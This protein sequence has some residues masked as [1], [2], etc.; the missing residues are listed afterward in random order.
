ME[1][2]R[3]TPVNAMCKFETSTLKKIMN[4]LPVS[5]TSLRPHLDN[6]LFRLRGGT[7]LDLRMISQRFPSYLI[8]DE[9]RLIN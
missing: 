3:S 6:L 8:S 4:Y 5:K 7:R 9:S 1:F 2:N